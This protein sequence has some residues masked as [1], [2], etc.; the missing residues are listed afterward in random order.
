L[1]QETAAVWLDID[2]AGTAP[3]GAKYL[4]ADFQVE[5]DIVNAATAITNATA[6]YDALLLAT[7]W[8]DEVTLVD[9]GDGTITMTQDYNG[10]AAEA[11][12][13]NEDDSGVGSIT[14]STGTTGTVGDA[15]E[16]TLVAEGGNEPYIW[17]TEDTLPEG[18]SLSLEG[19]L[20][21]VAREV[22]TF[23]ITILLTDQF[24]ITD[25]LADVDLVVSAT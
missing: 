2:A 8:A 1:S 12:P 25:S 23:T 13:E 24:G 11:D 22:G 6:F 21:G 20:E 5:V 18:I 15:Y 9:I 10:V 14:S 17:T 16:E 19:V 4:A 3:T 7:G